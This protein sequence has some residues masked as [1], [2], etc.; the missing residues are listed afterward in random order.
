MVRGYQCK[1]S[2]ML[3]MV[4]MVMSP[5][6]K[7][8][9]EQMAQFCWREGLTLAAWRYCGLNPL[10][11]WTATKSFEHQP[12]CGSLAW[13]SNMLEN[14]GT[15]IEKIMCLKH[16]QYCTWAVSADMQWVGA[17]HQNETIT[18]KS[19]FIHILLYTAMPEVA[20]CCNPK[21]SVHFICIS[22][23]AV[24]RIRL[25]SMA[26]T[27]TAVFLYH[28]CIKFVFFPLLFLLFKIIILL[29]H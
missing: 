14:T 12:L 4:S 18:V 23:P 24:V 22:Y 7:D 28:C 16:P 10:T 1:R 29:A 13:K 15:Q 19:G 5:S 20:I 26:Q 9:T 8:M 6:S 11:F 21:P 17:E 3:H 27:Q 2:C 25:K